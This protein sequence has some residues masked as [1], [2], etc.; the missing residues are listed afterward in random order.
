MSMM[1]K[2]LDKAIEKNKKEQYQKYE[3]D[4][5]S[6]VTKNDQS[7]MHRQTMS[8]IMEENTDMNNSNLMNNSELMNMQSPQPMNLSVNPE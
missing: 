5:K 7:M 1:L 3:L 6:I 2:S 4:K 8:P